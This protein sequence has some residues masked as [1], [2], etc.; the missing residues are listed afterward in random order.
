VLKLAMTYTALE[1]TL[2]NISAEQLR[3]PLLLGHYAV[4]CVRQLIGQRFSGANAFRE[5]EKRILDKV[6][7]CVITKRNLLRALARHFQN[8]EQFN[9]VFEA[10]V[11]AGALYTQNCGHGR[12]NVSV[13]PLD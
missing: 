4:K 10:M 6:S 8:S 12:V 3:A 7:A 2:P 11:R 13:E 5:L 1:G 9:R